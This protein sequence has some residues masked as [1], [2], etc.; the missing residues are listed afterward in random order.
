M[1]MDS[2]VCSRRIGDP[3]LSFSRPD[4]DGRPLA[5]PKPLK[6][7]SSPQGMLGLSSNKVQRYHQEEKVV[8]G[9]AKDLLLPGE[10]VKDRWRVIRKLGGGGFGEIYEAVD[11]R[12]KC[13][14]VLTDGSASQRRPSESF[15]CLSCASKTNVKQLSARSGYQ[16]NPTE[17]TSDDVYKCNPS[18]VITDSGIGC[19]QISSEVHIPYSRINSAGTT[20]SGSFSS[21]QTV[22][23]NADSQHPGAPVLSPVS[24]T[25]DSARPGAK[26]I[27]DTFGASM[28][29]INEKST[30][31]CAVC[32]LPVLLS[33]L[34]CIQPNQRT[35]ENCISSDSGISTTVLEPVDYR[36]A[37]KVESNRQ[38]RQ[39]LRM[40]VAVLRRLQGKPNV[41]TLYGCGKNTRFNYMVMSLQGKNLAELRRCLPAGIFTPSSAFRLVVQCLD[42]LHTLH[43]A[44][45]LHRDVKPSNFTVQRRRK[46]DQLQVTILD[47][48][49]A[50]PYTV[51]GPG[52]EVRN[53][54]PVAGFRGTV[55]YASVHA[56]EHRDLARRDDL[57]SLFYMLVEF[58][59]GQLPWRRIRDKDLVGQMKAAL[60]HKE[61]AL[62]AGIHRVIAE[63]WISHLFS[64]DYRSKPDYDLLK[65]SLTTWLTE[66]KVQWTDRYDWDD[67]IST[68]VSTRI[69][70]D[71]QPGQLRR[72][73][74][75]DELDRK[76]TEKQYQEL[77]GV[78]TLKPIVKQNSVCEQDEVNNMKHSK[79]PGLLKPSQS[80]QM[81]NVKM[82][83][84]NRSQ[85]QLPQVT[86]MGSRGRSDH[87]IVEDLGIEEFEDSPKKRHRDK[88]GNACGAEALNE[89]NTP[90][91]SNQ[92]G[93]N[94]IV[95]VDLKDE[96]GSG[97]AV[98]K[99][100]AESEMSST[101]ST[102]S[103]WNTESA[104][105]RKRVVR[106]VENHATKAG[107]KRKS[108]RSTDRY[109]NKVPTEVQA[110]GISKWAEEETR[111]GDKSKNGAINTGN[112]L[113][114]PDRDPNPKMKQAFI[115]DGVVDRGVRSNCLTG[116][117]PDMSGTSRMKNKTTE[118]SATNPRAK[119][120]AIIQNLLAKQQTEVDI[121][122][123]KPMTMTA[124]AYPIAAT[125]QPRSSSV[126]S[127][128]GRDQAQTRPIGV[129]S[130][131]SIRAIDSPRTR[132]QNHSLD[133]PHASAPF[134]RLS[135]N[136]AVL[137]QSTNH[138]TFLR[139]VRPNNLSDFRVS[140]AKLEVECAQLEQTTPE[141]LVNV[142][143]EIIGKDDPSG[144][145]LGISNED[146]QYAQNSQSQI[147][148][149]TPL[150]RRRRSNQSVLAVCEMAREIE[151]HV[152]SK[153]IT[154]SLR[155]SRLDQFPIGPECALDKNDYRNKLTLN[156]R[157]QITQASTNPTGPLNGLYVKPIRRLDE[158][159]G[160]K[161]LSG[162]DE[163]KPKPSRP[164]NGCFM[165]W[166]RPSPQRLN[167]GCRNISGEGEMLVNLKDDFRKGKA[168]SPKTAQSPSLH[169]IC[170]NRMIQSSRGIHIGQ[171]PY[172]KHWMN[173]R[174]LIKSKPPRIQS[175]AEVNK[176]DE[177]CSTKSTAS[178]EK[179]STSRPPTA[180]PRK[181]TIEQPLQYRQQQQQPSE[182]LKLK[183]KTDLNLSWNGSASWLSHSSADTCESNLGGT[184]R[185]ARIRSRQ[186]SESSGTQT[187]N[188]D[189]MRSTAEWNKTYTN[190]GGPRATRSQSVDQCSENRSQQRCRRDMMDEYSVNTS[191]ENRS[192]G[193]LA[194]CVSFVPAI[195]N[196]SS[197]S[198]F[199]QFSRTSSFTFHRFQRECSKP[200]IVLSDHQN[201]S[202]L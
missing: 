50:R 183:G 17:A 23:T 156:K 127:R 170:D 64:L 184:V 110:T 154:H 150:P 159:A 6:P 152:P 186:N 29:T 90:L 92:Q 107:C 8:T 140:A 35:N 67:H 141:G 77:Q 58:V 173:S 146:G 1:Q 15:I 132:N 193:S 151:Q 100:D 122:H 115:V 11:T 201:C 187:H 44:G 65:Q 69:S 37:V 102:P 129:P 53:P 118:M 101:S 99:T 84:V 136:N 166:N 86:E 119:I 26:F 75:Q 54:R 89:T 191:S 42:A 200:N 103:L 121:P 120:H 81:L 153:Q 124:G 7:F 199:T 3:S 174:E 68:G 70:P 55:R 14:P 169:K 130:R 135:S 123:S 190:T 73:F 158:P 46:E 160:T 142:D 25:P 87:A 5:Q 62:K 147:S 138:H 171:E 24:G 28:D 47:F 111:F 19:Q 22:F 133:K 43:D 12:G 189:P 148:R 4:G 59:C 61:M 38:P 180:T 56:H 163:Q 97:K 128:M 182:T 74:S 45:F 198:A 105:A 51:S 71:C 39:V 134:L 32:G 144:A 131:E 196:R 94:T 192:L 52:S 98:K 80:Q 79:W 95:L 194:K 112:S 114:V 48:G 40:E 13:D 33:Q 21:K 126:Q 143:S 164:R 104:T 2:I 157:R 161:K 85:P 197:N 202:E 93:S 167:R 178:R 88:T 72:I 96:S 181:P 20:T 63:C 82:K 113:P 168:E 125:M 137:P 177:L 106:T 18:A 188:C 16:I 165:S 117:L 185:T 176:F 91:R 162:N 149:P 108:S 172:A 83:A 66:H 145:E 76:H 10:L 9:P 155:I 34:R 78:T 49:L 116:E 41:C 57:W 195:T 109:H 60:D 30:Y 31:C 36:V 139:V 27:A 175:N 179:V